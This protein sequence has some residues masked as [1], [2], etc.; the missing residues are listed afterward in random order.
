MRDPT[1]QRGRS[2]WRPGP[3]APWARARSAGHSAVMYRPGQDP[4]VR[5]LGGPGVPE[6]QRDEPG[7]RHR[8]DEPP[9]RRGARRH[10]MANP[11]SYH[12][13]IL[14]PN[15]TVMALGGDTTSRGTDPTSGVLEPE[16]WD[17][18]TE[19]WTAMAHQQ[20]ARMYHET[21][22]LLP[23][24]RIL[25]SGSGANF[26][27]RDERSYEIFSP[28][29][30]QQGR[31]ARRSPA[32]PES[33]GTERRSRSTTP[34]AVRIARCRSCAW[35]RRPTASTRTSAS[36]GSTSRGR[37]QPRR[38]TARRTGTSPRPAG[39]WC[40]WST[41]RACRRWRRSSRCPS[42]PRATSRR[43][44]RPA[45]LTATGQLGGVR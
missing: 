35:G 20:V 4:Q 18:A 29:Y 38:W 30:L 26:A 25:L 15:G 34:D 41:T 33:S 17:P 43:P 24:G 10:P 39:T 8:H 37:R 45:N 22:L 1:R 13:L 44:P 2:T 42:A 16:I 11:R 6:Y 36:C 9:R 14:L 31:A 32:R 21:S 27:G 23:D 3:G 28:P 19:V 40:S 5:H 12:N 7:R